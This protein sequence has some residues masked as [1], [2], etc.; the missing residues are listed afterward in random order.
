MVHGD[1][2]LHQYY[3][4]GKMPGTSSSGSGYKYSDGY[5]AEGEQSGMNTE[6]TGIRK[7]KESK[8]EMQKIAYPDGD[9]E[10][11]E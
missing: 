10:N 1:A 5:H 6:M 7:G 4:D 11:N 9:R 3:L 8:I 2:K